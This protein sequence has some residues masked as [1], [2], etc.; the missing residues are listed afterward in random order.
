MGRHRDR[1]AHRS[2]APPVGPVRR[3]RVRAGLGR[4]DR[5]PPRRPGQPA[6]AR[7]RRVHRRRD[8]RAARAGSIPRRSPACS[9][10]TPAVGAGPHGTP[11]PRTAYAHPLLDARVG[12]DADARRSPTPSSTTSRTT[13]WSRPVLAAD[14]GFDFVDVKHCHGYLLHELLGARDR[15]GP[16]GGDLAGRTR[17]LRTVVA[18]IRARAPRL[19]IAVRLSAFD[20]VP[21]VPGPDGRGVPE[22]DGPVPLRVRRRRQRPRRRPHRGAR[23][24]RHPHRARHRARE[25]H[26]GQPV[27]QP[28]RPTAGLLPAVGRLPAAR[29]PARGRRPPARG[30][31]RARPRAPRAHGDR[32]RV[33][34][35][36]GLAART[37]RRRSSHAAT[38]EWSGSAG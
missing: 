25:H 23:V 24:L 32:R 38:R 16:Y 15:P 26:R 11:A 19:A 4:G 17:F 3:Q 33:L 9:S 27:L 5:G 12:A 10:P 35:P 8:R 30:D 1:R 2:R 6:P 22:A 21:F 29:G 34:V 18:G 28:A 36:A 37:S 14:A 13:T 20:L 31:R 7:A